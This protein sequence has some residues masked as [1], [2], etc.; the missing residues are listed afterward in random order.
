MVN[1]IEVLEQEVSVTIVDD[2]VVPQILLSVDTGSMAEAGGVAVFTVYT[3]GDVTSLTGIVV[4]LVYTGVAVSGGDY[5][6]MVISVTI[7]AGQTGVSFTLTA[8]Q[9]L[10]FE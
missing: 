1:G 5:T 8:L 3:S 10:I 6:G 9:D 7:P 2:E 4:S